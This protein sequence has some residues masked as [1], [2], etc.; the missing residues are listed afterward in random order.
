[1]NEAVTFKNVSFTPEADILY[2]YYKYYQ[3]RGNAIRKQVNDVKSDVDSKYINQEALNLSLKKA[4][5]YLKTANTVKERY[6]R[7]PVHFFGFGDKE[8]SG[9]NGWDL[10]YGISKNR[11]SAEYCDSPGA[12]QADRPTY[13]V[14]IPLDYII[15]GPSG[16]L[17]DFFDGMSDYYINKTPLKNEPWAHKQ[18]VRYNISNLIGTYRPSKLDLRLAIKDVLGEDIEN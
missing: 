3:S 8:T 12:G 9:Y 5:E 2:F 17:S 7:F 18:H 6:D 4:D 14:D 11:S 10:Y 13:Y 1:M 15:N 16:D